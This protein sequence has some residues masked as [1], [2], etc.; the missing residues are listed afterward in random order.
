[1]ALLLFTYKNPPFTNLPFH[2]M[3]IFVDSIIPFKTTRYKQDCQSVTFVLILV[4]SRYRER[5]ATER[6]DLN[7]KKLQE[8]TMRKLSIT[9]LIGLVISGLFLKCSKTKIV[10]TGKY[11]YETV[12]GDPLKARIYTLD[13]GLKVYMTVYKDA[14]RIQTAIAVKVGHKNDP[15]DNT[16]MAHYLEHLLFK[17]TDEFGSLDWGK[18][19][20]EIDKI[21]DLFEAYRSET[22]QEERAAIYHQID[23]ISGVAAQYAIANEYDKLLVSM[24]ATGTNAFT[25]TEQ[26]V[27]INDVPSNQ[28][29]K[30]L[31]V[32]KERFEDPVFR[33]FHTELEVV[34]EEK[35]RSMD[36]DRRKASEALL[37]GLF[38]KHPYGTETTLG[39]VEHLKNP[40]LRSVMNYFE[41]YY[42]PNNMA[43]CLSG[44]FDPDT[45]IEKINNTFGQF[46]KKEVPIYSAPVEEPIPSPVVKEVFG[47]DAESVT[48]AF[49]FP[50]INSKEAD[51]L[52][53][54]DMILMNG[55]AGLIDINLNQK[56]QVIGAY[57]NPR[58][59]KDYSYHTL[60][61]RPRQGQT[62]EEVKD[63]LLQQIELIKEGDFPDWLATAVL[64]DLKLNE[65]KNNERNWGRAYSFVQSF[66]SDVPWESQ[67]NRFT[68]LEEITKQEIMDFAKHFIRTIL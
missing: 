41:T 55:Q 11:T 45:M 25:S 44:D 61:A 12:E 17:G 9:I 56:Q 19:K 40:S 7:L 8:N 6:G 63:L 18:E 42:V 13:N 62:L 57:S 34:Y 5:N 65:I 52:T 24:G 2:L 39:R 31:K 28:I 10:H 32:E 14:P 49:R 50:G 15:T 37:A 29:D 68:R 38:Q 43:L 26:T 1:M 58:L 30:W 36:N 21:T 66:T 67:V 59:M 35:N 60:G 33:L 22:D 3:Y 64:N 54:M 4:M 48:L 53:M 23:S 47:P 51:L 16:G 46:K 20:V 27:F